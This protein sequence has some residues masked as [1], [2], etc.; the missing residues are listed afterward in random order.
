MRDRICW[1]GAGVSWNVG[2]H[3]WLVATAK[4]CCYMDKILNSLELENMLV[5]LDAWLHNRY[6][7]PDG[8]KALP[9]PPSIRVMSLAYAMCVEAKYG[10]SKQAKEILHQEVKILEI[11]EKVKSYWPHGDAVMH[12]YDAQKLLANHRRLSVNKF[13]KKGLNANW[14]ARLIAEQC[15]AHYVR[16][17]GERLKFGTDGGKSNSP[18]T[19][20]GHLVQDALNFSGVKSNW[21]Q[22]TKCTCECFDYDR[23]VVMDW[24]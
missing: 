3:F 24:S 10:L 7:L 19:I 20:F 16:A 5:A 8:S 13:G 6:P 2:R 4:L 21:K 15:A 1:I 9:K 11:A 22:P 23:L 18:S 12:L 14:L 17:T